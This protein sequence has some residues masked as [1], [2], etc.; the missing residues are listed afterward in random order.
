MLHPLLRDGDHDP[1]QPPG[2]QDSHKFAGLCRLPQIL[3]PNIS[4]VHESHR[5]PLRCRPW[6]QHRAVVDACRRLS[7][8]VDNCTQ[9]CDGQRSCSWERLCRDPAGVQAG[10]WRRTSGSGLA[11]PRT[12]AT[13]SLD[14]MRAVRPTGWR[15]SAGQD[16]GL[17]D[18]VRAEHRHMCSGWSGATDESACT[19]DFVRGDCGRRWAVIHLGVPLPACSCGLPAGSGEQPSDACAGSGLAARALLGLAP[20]GV[21]L[22]TPVARGAGGLLPH[23]FTL[24]GPKTGRRFVLCGTFPRVTPG[25]R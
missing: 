3:A 19:P 16:A 25:C 7:T 6:I 23:R 4:D 12:Q 9:R 11:L 15:P 5:M 22:A 1:H 20:G 17:H 13:E 18:R 14:L 21:Y 24:T 2:L 10:A 8:A